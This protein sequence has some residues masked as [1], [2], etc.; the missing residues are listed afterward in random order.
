MNLVTQ[1]IDF[2]QGIPADELSK[3]FKPFR[4][5]S[6]KISADEKSTG[7][8]LAIVK[9][10][11]EAHQGTVEVE[12]VIGKGTTFTFTLPISN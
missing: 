2:G 7:L 12:S 10:I 6:A 5:T 3:L 4:T 1:I 8:G 11:V 9:K